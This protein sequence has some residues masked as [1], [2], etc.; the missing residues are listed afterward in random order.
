MFDKEYI[1]DDEF[2]FHLRRMA[3]E[4]PMTIDRIDMFVSFI[5]DY[6]NTRNQVIKKYEAEGKDTTNLV[7]DRDYALYVLGL[8]EKPE[9]YVKVIL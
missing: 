7:L 4:V 1:I 5:S 3:R 9:R 2:G 8:R 6:I